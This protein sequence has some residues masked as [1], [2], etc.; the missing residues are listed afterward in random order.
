MGPVLS[1]VGL[2]VGDTH[3]EDAH[4]A[5]FRRVHSVPPV[6]PTEG[7]EEHDV[8]GSSFATTFGVMWL[9][10]KGIRNLKNAVAYD[11][12][13]MP[14]DVRRGIYIERV[15]DF[16]DPSTK[17]IRKRKMQDD[18]IHRRE[19]NQHMHAGDDLVQEAGEDASEVEDA[20][21][22]VEREDSGQSSQVAAGGSASGR[23]R[24]SSKPL[25]VGAGMVATGTGT[26]HEIIT[27]WGVFVGKML[28]R[29]Q[30]FRIV[31]ETAVAKK[32]LS[33]FQM[34]K[35]FRVPTSIRE[36]AKTVVK[37]A[38]RLAKKVESQKRDIFH[39]EWTEK[40]AGGMP[41]ELLFGPGGASFDNMLV[42]CK[43]VAKILQT[44][45]TVAEVKTPCR[46]FGDIHGQ[47]RD[48]LYQWQIY[49][50]PDPDNPEMPSFVFNGDFVDR[51]RHQVEVAGL[52]CALKVAM[53][54][55][56][57]LVR[58][59]HED[60]GM[61]KLYGFADA[62]NTAF[63]KNG[64][65]IFDIFQEVFNLLPLACLIDQNILT[66]HGGIGTGNWSID[67]FRN[68][69]RPLAS[70]TMTR[71][72]N[73]WLFNILWSDPIEDDSEKFSKTVGVHMSPR[74]G[75][76]MEFAW[77]VTTTFCARN[78][79][80][81]VIRSHQVK[82]GGRGFSILH[83]EQLM[84]VFSARDYESHAND[85]ATLFIR[86]NNGSLVATAQVLGSLSKAAG[87]FKSKRPARRAS[88]GSPGAVVTQPARKSV[89]A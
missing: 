24:K 50:A 41:L 11:M 47:L 23:E 72:M 89:R 12:G 20:E 26:N 57:V 63:G 60:E 34:S 83:N 44:Q 28:S 67:D 7:T 75:K 65:K 1:S 87:V 62:C 14:T 29:C 70:K 22:S 17:D 64:V 21:D 48:L 82:E 18:V 51:G 84:R 27:V 3:I 68:I 42:L 45:P 59:N 76:A 35:A 43:A 13:P 86:N 16:Y 81:L 9:I 61:N 6:P 4:R 71:P 37:T 88:K 32:R 54:D 80:S 79:I 55:K 10:H 58:G 53:P 39:D 19:F 73:T 40:Q 52:L 74:G 38:L 5:S 33:V 31:L 78:S 56:I 30:D 69:E 8:E 77:N 2:G 25:P 15:Y 85:C 66:V 49:G 36:R 46:V